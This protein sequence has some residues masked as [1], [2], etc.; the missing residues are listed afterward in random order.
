[1]AMGG[2]REHESVPI[3]IWS[4]FWTGFFEL[5]KDVFTGLPLACRFWDWD[6]VAIGYIA[7]IAI[8]GSTIAGAIVAI[9]LWMFA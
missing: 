4:D 6:W 9:G 8:L 7:G 3:P 2:P 5:W 1:M